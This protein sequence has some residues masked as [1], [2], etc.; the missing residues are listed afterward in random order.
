[1][2]RVEQRC[3]AGKKC[4]ARTPD[5]PAITYKPLCESCVRDSQRCYDRLRGYRDMLELFKGY[6]QSPEGGA[7]VSQSKEPPTPLNLTVVDLIYDIDCILVRSQGY[8]MRDLITLPGGVDLAHD[9]W[10]AHAKSE[11]II[12]LEKTW[13]RRFGK[14]PECGLSTLGG[15][16]GDDQIV[17]TNSGCA[18]AMSKDEYEALCEGQSKSRGK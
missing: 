9:V 8:L 6:K 13:Q 14:C 18:H 7:R 2:A 16:A 15:F 3:G 10:R 12:G 17:C 4:L 11:G 5:G 1:M